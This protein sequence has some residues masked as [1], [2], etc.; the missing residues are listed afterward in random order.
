MCLI[1][2]NR[3]GQQMKFTKT[4]T[5][6][7]LCCYVTTAVASPSMN[8]LRSVSAHNPKSSVEYIHNA[9]NV[10]NTV[11]KNRALQ[12]KTQVS[13]R[14]LF[15]LG[16]A[17]TSMLVFPVPAEASFFKDPVK[18]TKEFVKNPVKQGRDII[19]GARKNGSSFIQNT[20]K[21]VIPDILDF[22]SLSRS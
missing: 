1:N 5:T 2:A 12:K 10:T 6:V 17:M 4:I 9:A 11:Q 14:Q 20:V 3:K 15:L 19:D 16:V 8:G 7:V 13:I 22:K 21:A 18:A